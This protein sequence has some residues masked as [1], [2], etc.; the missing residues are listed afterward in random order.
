ML[1][2]AAAKE[3]T[4]AVVNHP[5]EIRASLQ[6][7][8]APTVFGPRRSRGL[9]V[10][11]HRRLSVAEKAPEPCGECSKTKSLSFCDPGAA[12]S[13]PVPVLS[14]YRILCKAAGQT[15]TGFVTCAAPLA[16]FMGWQY[17][18]GSPRNR[19]MGG[20][21]RCLGIPTPPSALHQMFRGSGDK[22]FRV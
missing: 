8:C 15:R 9:E 3:S 22:G 18:R 20:T 1:Q 4:P 14:S 6:G 13:H 19:R 17:T 5:Q 12:S 16:A 2:A 10:R 11:R 21:Y 7:R